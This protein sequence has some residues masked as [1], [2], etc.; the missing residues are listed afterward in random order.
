MSDGKKDDKSSGN[1]KDSSNNETFMSGVAEGVATTLIH[2]FRWF[3]IL[4]G[5]KK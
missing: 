4:V 5:M 2:P 3:R 1:K